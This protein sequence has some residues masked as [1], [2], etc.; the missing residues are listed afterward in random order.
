MR[1]RRTKYQER[2]HEATNCPF[3]QLNCSRFH[4][5]L[6]NIIGIPF[7]SNAMSVHTKQC[8][9]CYELF[10]FLSLLLGVCVWLLLLLLL[11]LYIVLYCDYHFPSSWSCYMCKWWALSIPVPMNTHHTK[12]QKLWEQ[13]DDDRNHVLRT[14]NT[15]EWSN[16]NIPGPRK[17]DRD[18]EQ[19]WYRLSQLYKEEEKFDGRSEPNEIGRNV[20]V[21]WLLLFWEMKFLFWWRLL[22]W[23]HFCSVVVLVRLYLLC[24]CIYQ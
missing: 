2:K 3:I 12:L 6:T 15:F 24:L 8:H 18:R 21:L 23:P 10:S 9:T 16:W 4:D 19:N 11:F 14:F 17:K 13:N 1:E 7:K 5:E 20:E 22:F